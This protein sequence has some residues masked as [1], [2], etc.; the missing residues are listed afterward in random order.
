[1]PAHPTFYCRKSI[2]DQLG[3]YNDSFKIAGDFELMM[4]F[5]QKN[6]IRSKFIDQTL[7]SMRVGGISNNG[8]ASKKK[9]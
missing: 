1:M 2:Y 8:L 3:G 5:L 4:R 6:N 9:L 7:I